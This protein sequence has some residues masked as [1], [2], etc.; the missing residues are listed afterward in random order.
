MN[1][2]GRQFKA[3]GA[4]DE[5][6]GWLALKDRALDVAAEGITIADARLPVFLC[7]ISVMDVREPRFVHR[8]P[9]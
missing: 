5:L 7:L 3:P 8:L 4:P 1:D 6:A 2:E 9:P